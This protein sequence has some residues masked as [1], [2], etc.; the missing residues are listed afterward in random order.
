MGKHAY[1]ILLLPEFT[2]FPEKTAAIISQL[3]SQG[4]KIRFHGSKLP[5]DVPGLLNY[6]ER[7]SKLTALL[8]PLALNPEA[9]L[10]KILSADAIRQESMIKS[11]LRFTRRQNDDGWTYFIANRAP[12]P[13]QGTLTLATPAKSSVVFDPMTG[14][15][16]VASA[17]PTLH[18]EPGESRIIRTY[19]DRQA[20]GEA[21]KDLLPQDS[22]TLSA[23]WKVEFLEGGPALA[24][25]YEATQPAAWTD[26]PGDAYRNFSGS[27]RY[28]CTFTCDDPSRA[29]LDLGKV[30]ETARVSLNGKDLGISWAAPHRIDLSKALKQGRNQLEITVTN[31]AA[32]RI[33]DLDRRKVPWKAFREINFVDINY[34]PFDA[35]G[36][37]ALPSGLIGPVTLSKIK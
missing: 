22:I 5:D 17:S 3:Q 27:A 30:A 29:L 9:D 37:P 8:S 7:R 13:F 21:W 24:P 19:R 15:S 34:K 32:N 10:L 20:T 36:W 18:L 12:T 6:E 16:G 25:S 1:E 4:A 35:S 11:G 14:R 2:Y 26:Q 31:L 28:T 23:P 33:A